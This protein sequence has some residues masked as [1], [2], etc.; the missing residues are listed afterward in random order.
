MRF[1]KQLCQLEIY[2]D[3]ISYEQSHGFD[4]QQAV[5]RNSMIDVAE[6]F[7]ISDPHDKDDEVTY[8]EDFENKV[9]KRGSCDVF[10]IDSVQF[11][12]FTVKDYKY[13][14]KKYKKKGF[15]WISHKE[16]RLPHGVVAQTIAKLG[17][18]TVL[19]K[20]YIAEPLKNRF[21]KNAK[22]VVYE[23]RARLLEPKFFLERDKVA[24]ASLFSPSTVAE[25]DETI[26]EQEGVIAHE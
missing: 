1:V 26:N 14:L 5:I 13:L 16:G 10:V 2:I 11:S 8:F 18:I 20:N 25:N 9:K 19:V 17:Q 12:D 6:Y 4:L 23:E 3:W 22:Y 7:Q 21:G 15:I 24:K